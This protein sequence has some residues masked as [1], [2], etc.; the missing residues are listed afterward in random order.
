MAK[1]EASPTAVQMDK[2]ALSLLEREDKWL[3]I[4]IPFNGDTLQAGEGK[5]VYT[6]DYMLDAE[7]RL[8]IL[9][10]TEIFL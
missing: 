3:V 10:A 9:L 6:S 7:E 4:E 8:R 1:K 5:V 2:K